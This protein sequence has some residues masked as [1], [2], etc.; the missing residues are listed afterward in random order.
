MTLKLTQYRI[1]NSKGYSSF[2]RQKVRIDGQQKFPRRLDTSVCEYEYA[3]G[4][5]VDR[6]FGMEHFIYKIWPFYTWPFSEIKLST[7]NN[8]RLGQWIKFKLRLVNKRIKYYIFTFKY[9]F[10]RIW[11][12]T[13]TK[14]GNFRTR[15]NSNIPLFGPSHGS[16]IFK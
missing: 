3:I 6:Q 16:P 8:L 5:V 9:Y 7:R 12:H 4:M 14:L 10:G 1:Y 13:F 15:S 11:Q 2:D